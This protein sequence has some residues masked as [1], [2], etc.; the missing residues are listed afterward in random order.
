MWQSHT[1]TVKA[2][3]CLQCCGSPYFNMWF[4]GWDADL[5]TLC[6]CFDSFLSVSTPSRSNRK[7]TTFHN[8]R[9][10]RERQSLCPWNKVQKW[11]ASGFL[12]INLN[13][14]WNSRPSL[15]FTHHWSTIVVDVASVSCGWLNEC[16]YFK[17]GF[18]IIPFFVEELNWESEV[19][20]P[21]RGEM[22]VNLSNEIKSK[23]KPYTNNLDQS[24]K[25]R[26]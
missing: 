21:T 15:S 4:S 16:L 24:I 18:A 12:W 26:F 14:L 9:R 22:S 23:A 17:L 10:K 1:I 7:K 11:P 20:M 13:V 8:I 3:V 5:I 6:V 19:K 25:P 2:A